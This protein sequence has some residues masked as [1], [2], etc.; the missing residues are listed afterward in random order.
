[1]SV[2]DGEIKYP[3]PIT[4]LKIKIYDWDDEPIFEYFEEVCAF[5]DKQREKGHVLVH[6]RAG[7]SRS[8]TIVIAYV[9]KKKRWTYKEAYEFVL[10]KRGII[11][12]NQG[13]INQLMAWEKTLK[14]QSTSERI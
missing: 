5:I 13:F 4:C 9:M 11:K 3:D 14:L 1:M 6:C 7:V 12:P 10:S 2:F 8:A